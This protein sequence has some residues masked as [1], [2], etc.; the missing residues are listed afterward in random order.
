VKSE[1]VTIQNTT[2]SSTNDSNL[3]YTIHHEIDDQGRQVEVRKYKPGMSPS[4]TEFQ[5]TPTTYVQSTPQTTYVQSTPQTTYVQSTPQT[6]YVQST[7][8]TTYVQSTPQ[9]YVQ[10]T[11][12][13]TTFV[14]STP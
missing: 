8:Q 9:S 3:P 13:T 11:P 12:Y 2:Y 5:S 7:P 10:S 1:P 6:T 14:D 4:E